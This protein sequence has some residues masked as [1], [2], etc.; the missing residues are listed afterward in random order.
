VAQREAG[1]VFGN[2]RLKSMWLLNAHN[3]HLTPSNLLMGVYTN[4]TLD[5]VENGSV[6]TL[7]GPLNS[8]PNAS[9]SLSGETHFWTTGNGASRRNWWLETTLIT[10]VTGSTPPIF[11]PNDFDVTVSVHYATPVA[12]ADQSGQFTATTNEFAVLELCRAVRPGDIPVQ[13]RIGKP[14]MDIETRFYWPNEPPAAAG[15]TA[16]LVQ[17]VET[18]ITGLTTQPIVLTNYYSQTYRPGHHNFYED[19]IFEPRLEPGIP[20]TTLN[21]LI[22]A[23][24][25]FIHAR[26]GVSPVKI[27]ILGLD[28][29]LRAF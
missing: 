16:P 9:N 21:E 20:A 12:T 1:D 5:Y 14:G 15:Y 26:W 17:F 10:N 25:Q 29:K 24:I 22:A 6:Q 11:T 13:R 19:F 8:W 23:N 4:G 27:N 28:G 7:S 18:R 3:M 2:H